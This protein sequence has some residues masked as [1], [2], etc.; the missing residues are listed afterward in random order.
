MISKSERSR[1]PLDGIKT[2]IL[3]GPP[4]PRDME[5]KPITPTTA[6][7]KIGLQI[8]RCF[9]SKSGYRAANQRAIFMPNANVFT[10][11]RGKIWWGDLDLRTDKVK[12]E[13]AARVLGCKLYV[14]SEFDG[15]WEES[16][17]SRSILIE[18]ARWQTGG[19]IG[20][21]GVS[22]FL[23]HSGL[24]IS[25]LAFLARVRRGRLI[26]KLPPEIALEIYKRLANL[27][28]TFNEI[29]STPGHKKWGLWW[30][31]A[32]DNLHGRAPMAVLRSGGSIKLDTVFDPISA[33]SCYSLFLAINRKL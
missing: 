16:P 28:T 33:L 2:I 11:R 3:D 7:N 15:R 31:T 18:R 17:L 9:G 21:P 25:Q 8:G 6:L 13:K 22:R 26:K 19:P 29:A 14:L 4:L 1:D 12:L 10:V 32:N 20:V 23:K 30:T 24:T 5:F 27:D